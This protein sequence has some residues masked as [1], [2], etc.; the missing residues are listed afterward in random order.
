M[1]KSRNKRGYQRALRR[2]GISP[3]ALKWHSKKAAAQRYR[4]ITA[5]I[6][7][8]DKSVLD[9]GCGFG[10]IIPYISEKTKD[11]EYTGIDRLP[12]FIREAKRRYPKQKFIV[13]DFFKKPPKEDFDIV[14][15]CGALNANVKDN[16][17]S[18]ERAIK[19]MFKQAKQVLVFNMAGRY[20]QPKTS[21]RSNV[22]F[23][24]PLKILEFC[25]GLTAKVVL[26]THYHS[27]DFTVAMF[28]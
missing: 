23:A 24:D 28:K 8:R 15:C 13:G 26:R 16:L 22:W 10:D 1:K 21:S 25:L 6:D 9:I 4:Q 7:F 5:D 3:K 19:E 14:I 17:G 18:R 11:F 2:Y 27:R 12:E 20:P